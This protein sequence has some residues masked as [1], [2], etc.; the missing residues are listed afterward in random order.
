MLCGN[1]PSPHPWVR[2]VKPWA[3]RVAVRSFP[4][5]G[6]PS[7]VNIGQQSVGH[8]KWPSKYAPAAMWERYCVWECLGP[9]VWICQPLFPGHYR[10]CQ[11][12]LFSLFSFFAAPVHK[13]WP[14]EWNISC[15]SNKYFCP[16]IN[17]S[18]YSDRSTR[19]QLL[20][21]STHTSD[22]MHHHQS[23]NLPRESPTISAIFPSNDQSVKTAIIVCSTLGREKPSNFLLHPIA[24][25]HSYFPP[26][27]YF[28]SILFIDN[29][30]DQWLSITFWSI[31]A[32]IFINRMINHVLG[33]APRQLG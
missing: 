17:I 5:L 23:I 30:F 26:R 3:P 7:L 19:A 12:L 20:L 29:N 31:T 27:S 33:P 16:R 13:S 21:H 11:P 6:D 14:A 32:T 15:Q 18:N 2:R 22:Q 25:V 8:C 1:W 4:G 9:S 24:R 10:R 28:L